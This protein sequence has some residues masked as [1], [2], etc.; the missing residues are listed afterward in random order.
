MDE[1]GTEKGKE[2]KGRRM[3]RRRERERERGRE[4]EVR[5]RGEGK[6]K[7]EELLELFRTSGVFLFVVD[8][9]EDAPTL[10]RTLTPR[11]TGWLTGLTKTIAS[12]VRKETERKETGK[13]KEKQ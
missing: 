4:G 8:Y 6:G 9:D 5:R 3:R 1:N 10:K 12:R 11:K 2:I 7:E 13:G